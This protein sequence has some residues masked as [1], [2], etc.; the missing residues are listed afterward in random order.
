MDWQL[1]IVSLL[2]MG[3]AA[4]VGRRAWRTWHAAG[5]SCGSGCGCGSPVSAL[6]ARGPAAFIPSEQ[7]TLRD[8]R[9]NQ[10]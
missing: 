1:F 6:A 9:G 4:Y 5:K 7:L 2:V 8:G 3:A 10:R